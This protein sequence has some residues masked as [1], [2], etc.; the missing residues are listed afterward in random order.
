LSL[1]PRIAAGIA[2][3]GAA[4]LVT[5]LDVLGSAPRGPGT[6]M[7]VLPDGGIAGSIGGGALEWRVLEA[8]RR[9]FAQ[10]GARSETIRQALG[11]DLGQC[12]GGHATLR[13]EVFGADDLGWIAPLA[14]A[15]QQHGV[16]V[17]A[18]QAD[19]A[20]RIIRRLAGEARPAGE[21]IER[22]GSRPTPLMLFGAGHVGRALVLALAPL[23][24]AVTW[25]DSRAE[26]FPS[27]APGNVS[28]RC[29][30][31]PVAALKGAPGGLV[32][33]MTHSHPLDLALVAAALARPQ[34]PYVGLIGSDTKRARFLGQLRAAGVEE[35]ALA[36]L[37]C[38]I[39]GRRLRD[40]APAVIAAEVAV[41]L[42]EARERS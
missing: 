36:R 7:V 29:I 9:L 30:A 18:G 33:V 27:H 2:E 4:A 39:G 41:E 15:E 3:Q 19:A 25:V 13:I 1:W 11:P 26:A 42:L 37:V 32:A 5:M 14:E 8:T 24:F 28:M 6:Q 16:V 23:P 38:P 20:G 10:G 35:A 31:D 40:K 12:C 21:V 17:T 22:F 34:F